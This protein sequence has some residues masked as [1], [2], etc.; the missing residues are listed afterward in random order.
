[1]DT[2]FSR[3]WAERMPCSSFSTLFFCFTP[4]VR[5][6]LSLNLIS[7][8][9]ENQWLY[10]YPWCLLSSIAMQYVFNKASAGET[11]CL[12]VCFLRKDSQQKWRWGEV[13]DGCWRCHFK[14]IFSMFEKKKNHVYIYTVNVKYDIQSNKGE[15][16][17]KHLKRRLISAFFI[18]H[19]IWWHFRIL[20]LHKIFLNSPLYNKTS[21]ITIIMHT[22]QTL[23]VIHFFVFCKPS[24]LP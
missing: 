22:H 4:M 23:F 14:Y 3:D 18:L 1:M 2:H 12:L 24:E 7:G 8:L 5:S 15:N 19:Y 13:N 6:F 21:N 17:M 9:K 11:F 20:F 16:G 10:K